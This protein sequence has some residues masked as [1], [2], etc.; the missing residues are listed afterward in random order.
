MTITA[1]M[2][3]NPQQARGICVLA[4]RVAAA[5]EPRTGG[6]SLRGSFV[7]GAARLRESERSLSAA[8]RR[9]AGVGQISGRLASLVLTLYVA[10]VWAV[11]SGAPLDGAFPAATP[12]PL[13]G[14]LMDPTW[15]ELLTTE[16]L[17]D[18]VTVHINAPADLLEPTTKPLRLVFYALPNGNSVAWTVGRAVAPGD[19]WRY[20]IQH[21]GAQTRLVRRLVGRESLVVVYLEAPGRSWPTW[22]RLHGS[23]APALARDI[24]TSIS[25]RFRSWQPRWELAAHS[26]GGS[27]LFA[28]IEANEEIPSAVQRLVFLD[29]NY[30]FSVEAGHAR[31]LARWLRGSPERALIIAAYDDR[32]V[33]L[34]GKPLI[35]PTGGTWR[36]TERMVAAL[37]EQDDLT[38]KPA[39]DILDVWAMSGQ[40]R[41]M[42]HTN[43]AKKILHTLLVERNGFAWGL[44]AA[45]PHESLAP[46]FWGEPSYREFIARACAPSRIPLD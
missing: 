27:F 32:H 26:G 23:Q 40:I 28:L 3:G 24:V 5:N 1:L 30:G 31:R 39:G 11:A 44:L 29:A 16:T 17:A 21:I 20:G 42:L 22:R 46:P 34:N 8:G 2:Q 10:C 6:L 45:S 25:Q 37:A 4:E 41:I 7:R 19:D 43:P 13:R 14:F 33:T 15:R 12:E 18:G 36:A 35:S 38:T 9:L